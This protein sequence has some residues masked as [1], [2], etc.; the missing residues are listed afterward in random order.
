MR[1]GLLNKLLSIQERVETQDSYGEAKATW[2]EVAKVYGSIYPVRG[3]ERYMSMEK[4]AT[5]TH[6]I[7][8][9]FM[10]NI[11]AKHRIVYD[12]REF[13]I[14]SVLNIAER[15]KQ[16]KIIAKESV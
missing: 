6:E 12:G 5:A 7:N 14:L 4:H 11:S 3:T 2:Q 8:I 1:A 10:Q 9:R 13:D 15:N 16:M